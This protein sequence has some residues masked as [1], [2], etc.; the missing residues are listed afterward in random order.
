MAELNVTETQVRKQRG[1]FAEVMHRLSKSPLAMFGLGFILLLVFCAVF[2][3]WLAPYPFAKQNLLHMFEL[4][5]A[6][7]WL[8]TDE[9]GRDIL[10]RLIFGARV[11]LQVGFIAVGISLV[12]G[13]LLGAFAGFYGGTLDN[14]IMRV[15]DVLL[16]IPQTLLAIAIAA[17][18]G[19]GLYNLMIAVGISAVPNYARIV[20][21][22]VLSI[23][24]ASSCATSF[25][26]AWPRSSSSPRWASPRRSSTRPGCRS[27]GWASSRPIPNG[28]PCS[29]A[30]VSTSATSRI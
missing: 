8:G 6:Q 17:A 10:S 29:P 21:G 27:S 15:M 22:S 25:P 28:A 23:R 30:G 2:A 18:L 11:S 19:P 13:G 20:R 1:P 24:G 9:F 7:Y 26:T 12:V 3:N 5:S 4:P 14:V 16:A